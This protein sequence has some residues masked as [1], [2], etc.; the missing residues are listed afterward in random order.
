MRVLFKA[1]FDTDKGNE[2]IHSGE[3]PKMLKETLDHLKPEAAYFGPEDGCRTCWLF[4]DLE[5]SSQIPAIAEP[6]FS[7]LGARVSF[8]PVMN[9]D[10]L[11]KGLAQIR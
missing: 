5:D 4:I 11:Q 9:T 10:D 1:Q 6:F 7:Q 8:T 2:G 3:M